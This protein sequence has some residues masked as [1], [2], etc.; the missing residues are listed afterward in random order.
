[1]ANS[2]VG[3]R[4]TRNKSPFVFLPDIA[5]QI[6]FAFGHEQFPSAE[7]TSA[8]MDLN[9]PLFAALN[10]RG[11]VQSVELARLWREAQALLLG[12]LCQKAQVVPFLQDID[13]VV[14]ASRR[15]VGEREWRISGDI[16][17]VYDSVSESDLM[18]L[19]HRLREQVTDFRRQQLM[20]FIPGEL[21]R[22]PVRKAFWRDEQLVLADTTIRPERGSSRY[23]GWK[24]SRLET[25][26]GRSM[27]DAIEV[28]RHFSGDHY[29]LEKA[30]LSLERTF[31]GFSDD[32]SRPELKDCW[33]E[34]LSTQAWLFWCYRGAPD[35]QSSTAMHDDFMRAKRHLGY[36]VADDMLAR[37][38]RS[39]GC[40]RHLLSAERVHYLV[41]ISV[42]EFVRMRAYFFYLARSRCANDV[43]Y[44][45][46]DTEDYMAA[47]EF[48]YET[49]RMMFDLDQGNR[50][51]DCGDDF[52][53]TLRAILPAKDIADSVPGIVKAKRLTLE[54]LNIQDSSWSI[55]DGGVV[56][57]YSW[58]EN[59]ARGPA[60]KQSVQQLC[61][62]FSVMNMF[63]FLLMCLVARR[64]EGDRYLMLPEGAIRRGTEVS[65]EGTIS[66]RLS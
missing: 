35:H 39:D 49:L 13:P 16:F 31:R 51:V 25:A 15:I 56:P 23:S 52:S 2:T 64:S 6:A 11:R 61:N 57:M 1:M 36:L 22:H 4:A 29:E 26:F 17:C 65:G 18:N 47:E 45:S 19:L 3:S 9:A 44:G 33:N 30:S 59:G 20:H 63:E 58:L 66:A 10:D 7:D 5:G 48:L 8:W 27:A 24:R 53:D 38:L 40:V 60:P 62:H 55:M 37:T 34:W 21:G 43:R 12:L 46:R 28:R 54:R 41:A 42:E 14:H 32:L 50:C